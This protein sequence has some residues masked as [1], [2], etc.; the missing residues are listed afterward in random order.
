MLPLSRATGQLRSWAPSP[1]SAG[2]A[3]KGSVNQPKAA[4]AMLA[5]PATASAP[6]MPPHPE[7]RI[8]LPNLTGMSP[9]RIVVVVVGPL[10]AAL[11]RPRRPSV[12]CSKAV[13]TSSWCS[14]HQRASSASLGNF[15]IFIS[16]AMALPFVVLPSGVMLLHLQS[17]NIVGIVILGERSGSKDPYR[18]APFFGPVGCVDS[19]RSKAG[20]ASLNMAGTP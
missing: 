18:S 16:S 11:P 9:P 7:M 1:R 14:A 15:G 4:G 12:A 5:R 3:Q 20:R 2:S 17:R 8:S 19:V 6:A 13:A 10:R